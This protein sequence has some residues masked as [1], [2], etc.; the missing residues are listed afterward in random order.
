[1]N[2]PTISARIRIGGIFF[3][4]HFRRREFVVDLRTIFQQ[5]SMKADIQWIAGA[6]IPRPARQTLAA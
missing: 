1:V 2:Y 5:F 4:F 6:L 3:Q